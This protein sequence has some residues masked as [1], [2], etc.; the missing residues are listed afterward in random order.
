MGELRTIYPAHPLDVLE[1][2]EALSNGVGQLNAA[3]A[4][5]WSPKKL[6]D[7]MRDNEFL[8]M[9]EES[10]IRGVETIEQKV[11]ELASRGNLAAAT[12]Y[13]YCQA[14]DRG[15]RPPAQRVSVSSQTTVKV[16]LVE[17]AKQAVMEQLRA[18][19]VKALQPGGPLDEIEDADVVD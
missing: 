5:G 15:W 19:G 3:L 1:F 17:G 12:L 7:L 14:P 10:R 11:F 13:L 9:M 8:D 16:E 4:V 6:R 2:L 18:G